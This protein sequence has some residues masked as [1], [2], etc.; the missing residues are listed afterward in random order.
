MR[1]KSDKKMISIRLSEA[2]I[3]QI[4]KAANVKGETATEYIEQAVRQ[5]LKGAVSK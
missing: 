2:L 1:P 5:S 4:K 3:N